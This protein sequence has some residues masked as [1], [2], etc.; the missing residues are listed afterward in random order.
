LR[1][2]YWFIW[3]RRI[4]QKRQETMAIYDEL[5]GNFEVNNIV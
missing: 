3:G 4:E 1:P 5:N 2:A